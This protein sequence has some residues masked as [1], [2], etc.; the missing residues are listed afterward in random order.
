MDHDNLIIKSLVEMLKPTIQEAVRDAILESQMPHANIEN[1][2]MKIDEFAEMIGVTIGSVYVMKHS[3]K[4]P[5][6]VYFKR[7]RRILFSR[8]AVI[9]WI[10][11]GK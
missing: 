5:E 10:K 11:N 4:I 2:M 8:R 9:D 1:D 6:N 7:G 3:G